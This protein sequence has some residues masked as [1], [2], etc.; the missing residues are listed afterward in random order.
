MQPA[1]RL[2]HTPHHHAVVVTGYH[3]LFPL[4]CENDM[5]PM[6]GKSARLNG[7]QAGASQTARSLLFFCSLLHIDCSPLT[8]GYYKGRRLL[9]LINNFN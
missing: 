1:C 5:Q 2:Q 4:V 6:E 9:F 8:A 7:L 3:L